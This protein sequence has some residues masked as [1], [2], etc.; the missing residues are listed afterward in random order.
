MSDAPTSPTP[1]IPGNP[2]TGIGL[3]GDYGTIKTFA[4][5]RNLLDRYY[6][7]ANLGVPP[8][9]SG[10]GGRSTVVVTGG[11]SGGGGITT[12]YVVSINGQSGVVF[13]EL[14][15]IQ[16][17]YN[18]QD[19]PFNAVGDGVADDTAAIQAAINAAQADT[20]TGTVL[21]PG[22]RYLVSS[23]LNITNSVAIIGLPQQTIA[24]GTQIIPT[25]GNFDVIHAANVLFGVVL[26]DFTIKYSGAIPTGNFL[27]I[28][29]SATAGTGNLV[30]MENI[31]VIGCASGFLFDSWGGVLAINCGA[32]PY[33]M[34]A[35]FPRWGFR[36]SEE[37]GGNGNAVTLI[38]CGVSCNGQTHVRNADGFVLANGYNSLATINCGANS[39][40]YAFW[41]TSTNQTGGAGSAPAFFNIFDGTGELCNTSIQ[42]DSVT[43]AC[44]ID[45]FFSLSSQTV[46]Q[47]IVIASGVGA[48]G[49]F[50]FNNCCMATTGGGYYLQGGGR[51]SISGGVIDNINP[52]DGIQ[53]GG[54]SSVNISGVTINN[55]G[56][57]TAKGI[58]FTSAFAGVAVISGVR[59]AGAFVGLQFDSGAAGAG[60]TVTGSSFLS[61]ASANYVDNTL[62]G[63]SPPVTTCIK[64]ISKCQGINP[65]GYP[66]PQPYSSAPGSGTVVTNPYA[67]DAVVYVNA[68]GNVSS[69]AVNGASVLGGTVNLS[70][71]GPVTV[72]VP[73]GGTLAVTYAA[74]T[75]IVG[76]FLL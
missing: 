59:E 70:G 74:G 25:T 24:G 67:E 2:S 9:S 16:H 21:L 10:N 22:G 13:L 71:T 28:R 46:G 62:T 76:W 56:G 33:D 4:Q 36:A 23:T 32:E 20:V 40:R 65:L 64:R 1:Q 34:A 58:H 44:Q 15:G 18:V 6:L 17:V 27:G 68:N 63:T 43:G 31:N 41:A 38:N 47:D 73:W 55:L 75:I 66:S 26:R 39:T 42:F 5:L 51:I 60:V 3:Q 12:P 61:N 8:G 69:V 29:F 57:A 7:P 37:S 48:N 72:T 11:G 52:G 50:T 19:S 54:A 35:G 49:P 45:N 53:I 30:Q 14:G